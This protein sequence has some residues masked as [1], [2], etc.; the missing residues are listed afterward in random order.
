MIGTSDWQTCQVEAQA[1]SPA[2]EPHNTKPRLMSGKMDHPLAPE[3]SYIRTTEELDGE[4]SVTEAVYLV[5]AKCL[6]IEISWDLSGEEL[7]DLGN[8]HFAFLS[9]A[10]MKKKAEVSTRN[11]SPELKASM[12]EAK[13]SIVKTWVENQV[14][15]PIFREKLIREQLKMRWI[16]AIKKDTGKAKA[17][18]VALGFQD[19]D[20]GKVKTESPTA[21]SKR[22]HV[23][24]LTFCD[25]LI[26]N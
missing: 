17:R 23:S 7:R 15:I 21:S 9:Q 16:L 22:E 1:H 3:E 5:S 14:C 13:A 18:M 10:A 24:E 20:L 25:I 19:A 26:A 8:D 12:K 4:L 11:A 2:V 6:V